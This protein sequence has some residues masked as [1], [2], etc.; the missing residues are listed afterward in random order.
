[1]I[2]GIPKEIMHDEARVAATPESVK[3]YVAD[4]HTVLVEKN[5]GVGALHSNE[6]YVAAGATIIESAQEIYDKAELIMKVKEPLFNEEFN[7]HE[8]D[9]MHNGQFL[10]TFIHPASPVNHEMV[11]KMAANGIVSLTMDC[12][13]RISRAQS[14]DALT[15]M[16]TCAGYKGM[17]M[18]ASDLIKFVPMM[19]TAAGMIKPVNALIIGVGV[20]GLQALATAKRLGAK[21]FAADIRPAAAE[22]A[23]S[24]G[25]TLVDTGVAPE[26]AIG[27]GGYA[28]ELPADVLAA[29]RER[30]A[31]VLP[32]MD[33]VFLSALVPGRVAPTLITEEM[34][35]TMKPGSVIV[36]IAIDQGGNCAITP[37][38]KREVKYGVT[39][40]GIKN[41]P[42]MLAEAST[43]MY[44][45]NMYNLVKYLVKDNTLN[46][47]ETD[48]IV[49]GMLTTKDGKIVHAGALAAMGG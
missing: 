47:D 45:A 39:L 5:A 43:L 46:L 18:A 12:V 42:G 11:K 41:I 20:G 8:V 13:P 24:L 49:K 19:P 36:D 10:I 22:Q 44:S 17:L 37:A 15:S 16:S 21:T 33:I 48:E 31:A 29:E 40:E 32:E 3:K 30:I 34:V 26:L 9:M 4:G 35:K 38:G 1:M 14:M 27:Q 7:K 23:T 28:L 6:A 2:I 25:A